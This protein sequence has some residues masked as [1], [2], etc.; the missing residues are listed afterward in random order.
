MHKDDDDIQITETLTISE[1]QK[2][3][4]NK[5]DKIQFDQITIIQII[6]KILFTT[7]YVDSFSPYIMKIGLMNKSYFKIYELSSEDSMNHPYGDTLVIS[8]DTKI[9]ILNTVEI[10]Y[11]NSTEIVYTKSNYF[12]FNSFFIKIFYI[13]RIQI[14]KKL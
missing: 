4:L 3:N 8:K 12:I 7:D 1:N 2:F 13:G 9:E 14:L 10:V 6:E 11:E 5:D